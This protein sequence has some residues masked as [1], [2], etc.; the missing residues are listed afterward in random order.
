ME[1]EGTLANI[2]TLR[3]LYI[4]GRNARSGKLQISNETAW[5]LLWLRDGQVV[6]AIILSKSDR[7]PLHAGEQAIL[8]LFTWTSGHYSYSP[9]PASGSY[10]VTIRRST[11]DLIGEELEHR[12]APAAPP[13]T[14]EIAGKRAP[15]YTAWLR[16]TS[17]DASP[18]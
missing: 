14:R 2:S 4:F 10:P 6:S 5:A 13:P 9:D 7:R 3:L 1:T 16:L 18:R 17:A 12:N 8:D 11:S 15:T